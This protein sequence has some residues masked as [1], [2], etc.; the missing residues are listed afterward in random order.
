MYDFPLIASPEILE[1]PIFD[2]GEPLIDI[3]VDKRIAYGPI[4][5]TPLTKDDYTLV[6]ETVYKKLLMAQDNLPK[7]LALRLYEG[8]RSITVQQQLFEH[9]K[10]RVMSKHSE[11][12]G[13]ALFNKITEVVSPVINFDGSKNIPPHN[14]G[15]A[16]DVEL[17]DSHGN[18]IDMGMDAKDWQQVSHKL[19]L[20]D[21]PLINEQQ[22]QNRKVLCDIMTAQGFVNYP[23]EWWHFSYGDRY[24]A[25]H[26]N[27]AYAIYGSI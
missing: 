11:L 18:A 16:V 26:H 3:K 2:N 21:S 6:R 20:T 4:P 14:T 8:Y 24:W 23:T 25:Y 17:V 12:T 7:G 15:A 19:C 10:K 5:E 27:K 1:I 9:E 22:R 13:Q